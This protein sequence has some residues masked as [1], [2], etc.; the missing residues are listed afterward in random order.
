MPGP[1]EVAR[2]QAVFEAAITRKRVSFPLRNCG[3][4]LF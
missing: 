4:P 1:G 3:H 2:V